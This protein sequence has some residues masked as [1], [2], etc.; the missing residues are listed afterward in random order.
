MIPS[1]VSWQLKKGTSDY[2][3]SAFPISN[4]YFERAIDKLVTEEGSLYHEPYFSIRMPF[5]A[6]AGSQTYFEAFN[7]PYTPHLHQSKSFDRLTN[8]EP[9]PTIIATGT[10]SGKTE[11][12]LYPILEY[13]YQ[14]RN[15]EGIKALLIYPMNA[16]ATDQAKRIAEFINA[17]EKLKNNISVGMY[18]G[19]RSTDPSKTMTEHEVITDHNTILENPPSILMTNYK[20]LDYLLVRPKDAKLWN[21]N[22]ERSLRFI[23]V[24]ELHTFDGAQGTDLACLIRRLK[25]RLHSPDNYVC[26]VGTSATI[27]DESSQANILRYASEIFDTEFTKDSLIMEDRITTQELLGNTQV[28]YDRIPTVEEIQILA[29][30]L[31]QDNEEIFLRN[32]I[33][34]WFEEDIE[35][36]QDEE[37]RCK[38][39]TQIKKHLFFRDL[40]IF[41]EG[42]YFQYESIFEDLS[43]RHSR[44]LGIPDY[45]T[46]L[47]SAIALISYAKIKSGKKTL[48]FLAVH[49]ELWLKELS[50][51]VSK[52]QVDETELYSAFDLNED[53]LYRC[54]PI[55]MCRECGNTAWLSRK[56]DRHTFSAGDLDLLY[57]S[58]FNAN[59]SIIMAYPSEDAS[60]YPDLSPGWICPSCMMMFDESS[61]AGICKDCECKMVHIFSPRIY[62]VTRKMFECPICHSKRG[63][64]IVGFRGNTELSVCISQL[65]SSRF[66]DDKKLISFTDNVQDA[67]HNSAFFNFKTNRFILRN[68][69]QRFADTDGL[70]LSLD[71]FCEKFVQNLIDHQAEENFVSTY[72]PPRLIWMRA[73]EQMI[74][75]GHLEDSKD[76]EALLQSI[77]NRLKYDIMLEYGVE[78]KAGRTLTTSCASSLTFSEDSISIIADM[79]REYCSS[80]FPD[81]AGYSKEQYE[82]IVFLI[83]NLMR[84]RGA[85]N[86]SNY[87]WPVEQNRVYVLSQNKWMPAVRTGR[88]TP[89]FL[90]NTIDV[91][92]NTELLD[93]LQSPVYIRPLKKMLPETVSFSQAS[94][95]LKSIGLF[96]K[97]I[98]LLDTI[99]NDK[100]EVWA[101]DK[102][103]V[104]ITNKVIPF[105]CDCCGHKTHVA[106]INATHVNGAPCSVLGC[107]GTYRK[108]N[109]IET[110][111]QNLY[112]NADIS[113]IHADEH[114]GLLSRTKREF[115]EKSFKNDGLERKPWDINLLSATPTL[116]MGIDVGSLST[117]LMTSMPPGQSQYLQRSGRAGRR[118]GNSL[119][120][121]LSRNRPYDQYYYTDPLE[122][123]SGIVDCPRIFLSA[124]AVLERQY[125]AYCMDNWIRDQPDL[126]KIPNNLNACLNSINEPEKMVFPY[127]FTT[128]AKDNSDRLFESFIDMF[129]GYLSEDATNSLRKFVFGNGADDCPMY[130]EVREVFIEVYKQRNSL[131]ENVKKCKILISELESKP[132]DSFFEQSIKELKN[133]RDA[134]L[135]VVQGIAKKNIFN[136]MTDEG[137]LPNYAFPESGMVLKAVLFRERPVGSSPQGPVDKEYY[138]YQRPSESAITELAPNNQFCAEG[139]ELRIDRIDLPT[140]ERE[141]W[142]LCPNCSH[143]EINSRLHNTSSCPRCGCIE[144]SDSHQ[145]KQL[146][147]PK[148]VYSFG[149]Y[150]D[151]IIKDDRDDRKITS[152]NKQTL[153]DVDEQNEILKAYSIDNEQY[154]FGYEFVKTAT[155]REINFGENNDCGETIQ[156]AGRKSKR[157]SFRICKQCG[158]V[159]SDNGG[160]HTADCKFKNSASEAEYEEYTFLYREL[161]TEALRILIPVV[162]T[163]DIDYHV[164][165]FVAAF[166]LG[167]REYFGNVNHL[168]TTISSVPI[169]AD[170]AKMYLVIYDSIPGG[171]GYLKQLLQD[172]LSMV[173]I[174]EKAMNR[175]KT[176]SCNN[177]PNK[178]GCYHCLYN[179]RQSRSVGL[180]RDDAIEMLN[181]ILGGKDNIKEVESLSK[182]DV[183]GLFDSALEAKF[184]GLLTDYCKHNPGKC[185]FKPIDYNNKKCY[186]LV[187]NEIKWIVEPQVYLNEELGVQV[188]SKPDFLFIAPSK[189]HGLKHV[190]LF[191]DGFQ[192]HHYK[193]DDDTLKRDA[194]IHSDKFRVWSLSWKDVN[195]SVKSRI[196]HAVR[197]LDYSQMPTPKM[198][199]ANVKAMG[200]ANVDPSSLNAFQLLMEYLGNENAEEE[201]TKR[202][203]A[204]A[205]SLLYQ[206]QLKSDD[207]RTRIWVSEY[208]QIE[209]EVRL[210]SICEDID[211]YLIGKWDP[212]KCKGISIYSNVEKSD[213]KNNK[214]QAKFTIFSELNDEDV[215]DMNTYEEWWNGFFHFMNVMQFLGKNFCAVSKKGLS[216]H[217]YGPLLE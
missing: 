45:E 8:D 66:N 33:K 20:M 169:S 44:L 141:M 193:A 26:S 185:S 158:R 168:K 42:H 133:E 17:N 76:K 132:H 115:V 166:M 189:A 6:S 116:E 38:L 94:D 68:S 188:D 99:D 53:Q 89:H 194:I 177:D 3:K 182:I 138:E 201:F 10:G 162:S 199:S 112:R 113:R 65:Y 114:T 111:Y 4:P 159:Q 47:N 80:N 157:S 69:I 183:N 135:R 125:V 187:I 170:C 37:V 56:N 180:S 70:G 67:A 101:I 7:I 83:L 215:D 32:S 175:L 41:T 84:Q 144:W 178:D 96:A 86:D 176:C 77:K 93:P 210:L 50:R 117:T 118:D 212:T 12:F 204:Y 43:T 211:K 102:K 122:M 128:Y 217:V 29:A 97:K 75:D 30:N 71:D 78:S 79:T 167:M 214:I 60:R 208:S 120:I 205:Q 196:D 186:E 130:M 81:M 145:V 209:K 150:E 91:M 123:I 72:I 192:F 142:R 16:L 62:P 121:I 35:N 134:Y 202:S 1:A 203:I 28:E 184:I 87:K 146:M 74:K 207:V 14:H 88:N 22:N 152:Y 160:K 195:F 179:Y 213:F 200:V 107:K 163:G 126:V 109:R 98:G 105:E 119:N 153:V 197:T 52:I 124:S 172:K 64:G 206:G 36:I 21:L 13:C 147:K 95:I 149:K 190:A 191:T 103:Q 63:L 61:S 51:L 129:R 85:F 90:S 15:E 55:V 31:N 108:S 164:E 151:S 198:Y 173:T 23:V 139:H 82:M 171:T 9:K 104:T 46:L 48:P 18:V 39:S 2:V 216:S 155:I 148:M 58:F 27:G 165:S 57:N 143:M 174:L 154:T 156:V 136:F 11:C 110:Y 92:R 127:N 181:T 49:V 5:R 19:G 73:Y 161:K 25:N 59:N 140:A 40:L 100:Y 24:D 137:L 34:Y 54:N 131:I 106:E